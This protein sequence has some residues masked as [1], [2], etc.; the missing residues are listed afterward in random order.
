MPGAG[1]EVE[2]LWVS[3]FGEPA[4]ITAA[5]EL[6][7]EILVRHMPLAPPYGAPGAAAGDSST[8]ED[9]SPRDDAAE[10]S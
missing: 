2:A 9:A 8:A 6:L 4:P 1:E 10:S 3:V 5:P 7:L